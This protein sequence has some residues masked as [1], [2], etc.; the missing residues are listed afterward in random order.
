[1]LLTSNAG[2]N[3]S[4]KMNAANDDA[5]GQEADSAAAKPRVRDRIFD[6]ACELFYRHGIRSVGV[7]AIASEAGTNKMSFYRSFPSKDDLVA[8]YLREQ[9][10]EYFDWWDSTIAPYKGDPLK[11]LDALFESYLGMTCSA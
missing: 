2:V 3:R 4:I 11:Q 1:M 8:E 10:R 9:E 5:A 6:T 7:D